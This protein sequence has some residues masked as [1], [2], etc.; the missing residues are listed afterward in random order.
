MNINHREEEDVIS[1]PSKVSGAVLSRR[2]FIKGLAAAALASN[3]HAD[4]APQAEEPEAEDPEAGFV[5][6]WE[7]PEEELKAISTQLSKLECVGFD[8]FKKGFVHEYENPDGMIETTTIKVLTGG[9]FG[10]IVFNDNTWV[11]TPVKGLPLLASKLHITELSWNG[12]GEKGMLTIAAAGESFRIK[13]GDSR[14]IDIDLA[15]QLLCRLKHKGE[16]NIAMRD[17]TNKFTGIVLELEKPEIPLVDPE[18]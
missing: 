9:K 16:E 1:T 3:A 8:E 5:H 12:E 17:K 15:A 13:R 2:D 4:E 11:L 10:R 6:E 7:P 18:Q 14:S